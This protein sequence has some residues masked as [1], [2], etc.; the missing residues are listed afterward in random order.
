MSKWQPIEGKKLSR[1]EIPLFDGLN[2]LVGENLAKKSELSFIENARSE[3]VGW[4]SKRNGYTLFGNSIQA[5]ATYG[6]YDFV[7]ETHHLLRI[8]TISGTTS[9]F[10]YTGGNWLQL[11]GAGTNLTASEFDFAT[12]LSRCF[13]VNGV[14][15]NRYIEADGLTVVDSSGI[16]SFFYN[17]PKARLVNYYRGRLYL[18]DYRRIDNTRERT[19]IAFSSQAV[20]IVS[21]VSGDHT[22]PIT[23]LNVTDTKYIKA[24]ALDDTLDIYRGGTLIGTITVTARS[25][26]TLTINSFGT[27]LLSSDEL[28]VSGT[29]D[30]EQRFRWDNRS[31]GI[32][33][34]EYDSLKNTSEEDLVLLTNIDTNM[35]IFTK[36]SLSLFNG[37]T[38][39]PLDLDIG[40]IS[41]KTFV[42]MLGQGIFLHYTGLYAI[43]GSSTP[44][45]LTAKVQ[46]LF[47]NA[48]PETLE[49]ACAAGNGFSYF[50]HLGDIPFYNTNGSLKKTL[51]DVVLEYNFR[52]NNIFIHTNIA[53]SHFIQFSQS[54]E[55]IMVFANDSGADPVINFDSISISESV[56]V[57]RT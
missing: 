54:S 44:R 18:G 51:T 28:W 53:M 39:R 26:T 23:T 12:A 31:S 42:K 35:V 9:I 14:D 1:F 25:A 56:T 48:N 5:T 6:L 38:V 41:K 40:C 49:Q 47:D 7:N 29:H 55:R 22:A 50:I 27:D 8:S 20:G 15:E 2:S 21:L 34:R 46:H 37:S 4:L 52:Q 30:G 3:K 57:V 24:G 43:T 11:S 19:G 13:V 45:L 16:T 10:L 36:N 32:N 17:S 33:V